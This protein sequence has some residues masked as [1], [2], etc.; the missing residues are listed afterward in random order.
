MPPEVDAVVTQLLADCPFL[1]DPQGAFDQCYAA[2]ATLVHD[3][4]AAGIEGVQ[5]KL[6]GYLGEPQLP[7]NLN[8]L[9][10]AQLGPSCWVHFVVRVGDLYIDITARQFRPDNPCPMVMDACG[11]RGLWARGVEALR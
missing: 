1:S 2:S 9:L 11:L 8:A 6:S 4:R 5:C 10:W 7:D 3:L